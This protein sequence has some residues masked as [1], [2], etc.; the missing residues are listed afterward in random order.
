MQ[1]CLADNQGTLNAICSIYATAYDN[2]GRYRDPQT[3]ALVEAMT[4]HDFLMTDRYR[5]QVEQLRQMIAQY[6]VEVKKTDAY[7]EVKKRLPTATLSG[8]FKKNWIY[9]E[10]KQRYQWVSRRAEFLIQHTGFIVIDIDYGDNK[11]ISLDRIMRT[12][13]HHRSIYFAMRSCSGMGIMALCLIAHPEHHKEH[14][15]AIEREFATMGIVIDSSCK[16]VSRLRFASYDS[17]YYL[18]T[19]ALPYQAMLEVKNPRPLQ[20]S[21]ATKPKDR[22]TETVEETEAKVRTLVEKIEARSIDITGDYEQWVHLGMSLHDM[23]CGL[24]YW[25]RI[26]VYR[27]GSHANDDRHCAQKWKTF[28]SGDKDNAIGYFFNICRDYGITLR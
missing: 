9:V 25:Q 11:Q 14:F 18:N 3:G 4:I 13:R 1:E 28:K 10:H 20:P 19:S 6:G 26:S 5:A 12:L 16:D 23:I 27:R 22:T 15:L 2:E 7:N 21:L 17:D 24:D 8:L